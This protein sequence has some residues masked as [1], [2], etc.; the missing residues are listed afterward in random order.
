MFGEF[1]RL[2]DVP[3]APDWIKESVYEKCSQHFDKAVVEPVEF[4]E[5]KQMY[6]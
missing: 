4:M 2:N 5:F 3:D 1:G 6:A